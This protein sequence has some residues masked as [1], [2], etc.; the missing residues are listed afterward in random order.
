MDPYA[1]RFFAAGNFMANHA[2]DV[3][4]I[5]STKNESQNISR[6]LDSIF[7]QTMAPLEVLVIDNFSTDDT[8]AIAR[9]KGAH[10]ELR[11]PERCAQRNHGAAISN[12]EFLLFLD[13]DMELTPRVIELCRSLGT[14]GACSIVIPERSAGSTFWAKCKALEK[15]I[16]LEDSTV[17]A[18]RFFCRVAFFKAG[19]YDETLF[20]F[21]DWDIAD[22]MDR[23]SE[24]SRISDFIIH[25]EGDLSLRKTFNKKRY[26]ARSYHLYRDK[27]SHSRPSRFRMRRLV[28]LLG[29]AGRNPIV[30]AGTI[31]MKLVELGGF[32]FGAYID[33]QP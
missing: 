22:R 33:R 5:V 25:H 4:V 31:W 10:V 20:A 32:L 3:S 15:L 17:E 7:A 6:C 18:P 24:R 8:A 11:G 23:I 19:G 30:T 14:K 29:M 13:A 21:E 9:E 28:A 27:L 12:G 26:Y 16:Y 1:H 2:H